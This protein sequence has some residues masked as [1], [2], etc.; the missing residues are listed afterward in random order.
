MGTP[1]TCIIQNTGQT[2][3]CAATGGASGQRIVFR[4]G[5]NT[6]SMPEI[7]RFTPDG[8]C[9]G[10]DTAA[11]NALDDYET[12]TYT[13]TATLGSG[14][15][16][17]YTSNTGRYIK[18]GSVVHIVGRLHVNTT[19]NN[20]TSFQINLPF[21]NEAPT[22]ADTSCVCHVIR[23]NGGDPVQGI[24]FFRIAPDSAVASMNNHEGQTY[25]DLG[26]TNAHININFTYNCVV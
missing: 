25:G 13:I 23:G 9:F 7:A 14:S 6:G 22:H 8:L 16:S 20:V 2:E 4:I 17:S 11:A 10:S 1:K 15:V 18:I 3:I 21:T 12:G 19:Q 5:A 26:A 24:R